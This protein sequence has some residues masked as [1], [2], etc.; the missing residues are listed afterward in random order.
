MILDEFVFP[1]DP[2]D[3]GV[4]TAAESPLIAKWA[5]KYPFLF[6]ELD[7]RTARNQA[8]V[9]KGGY[10]F[11]EWLAA[12]L[13]YEATGMYSLVEG[14]QG[15]KHKQKQEVLAKLLTDSQRRLVL[16]SDRTFKAQA[17]DLLVYEPTFSSYFFCEVKGPRDSLRRKAEEFF[18]AIGEAC[19]KPV[20]IARF[21]P[22]DRL[23]SVPP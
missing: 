9:P 18:R 4:F 3:R 1:F 15:V 21:V 13:L 20:V 6:D 19:G 14:Y 5:E 22:L 23:R 12:I 16:N 2:R 17:P 7:I 10:H 8:P 11:F